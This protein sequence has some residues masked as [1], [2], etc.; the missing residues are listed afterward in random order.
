MTELNDETVN[1]LV[2]ALK[3]TNNHLNKL[4]DV[5]EKISHLEQALAVLQTCYNSDD[6]ADEKV[7][8][9]C[10]KRITKLEDRMAKNESKFNDILESITQTQN[11]LKSR[12]DT[13]Q[14]GLIVV[15]PIIAF[16]TW[17][18]TTIYDKLGS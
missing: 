3:E 16:L 10:D 6:K 12:Q 5:P 4:K 2:F 17:L 13:L 9:L 15:T 8:E 14:G 1:K 7:R 11:N 18:I